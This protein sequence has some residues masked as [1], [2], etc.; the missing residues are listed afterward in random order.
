MTQRL[1]DD[2]LQPFGQGVRGEGGVP[3][4]TLLAAGRLDALLDSVY[5]PELMASHKPVLVSQWAKYYFTLLIPPVLVAN[6]VHGWHWPLTLAHIALALDERGVPQGIRFLGQGA[7]GGCAGDKPLQRFADLLDDNL[8]PFIEVLGAYGKLPRAV[9][10]SSV[11]DT[12]EQCLTRLERRD[13]ALA[14]DGWPLLD[15]PRRADG[16]VNPLF[17]SVAYVPQASG[18]P[19]RQRRACCLSYQVEWVGRCEHCPLPG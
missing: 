10:W 18:E 19:R 6:L 14:R 12:L 8:R 9:L 1:F 2:E 7:A 16:R 5:G 3:L 13:P 11:G 17:N 4:P 15:L